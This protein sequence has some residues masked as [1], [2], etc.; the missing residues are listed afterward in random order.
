MLKEIRGKGKEAEEPRQIR[1]VVK[2][3][4]E[5]KEIPRKRLCI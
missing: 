4:K 3:Q 2:P 5:K 1:G